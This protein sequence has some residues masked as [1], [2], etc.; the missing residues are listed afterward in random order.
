MAD[1]TWV[2]TD[3]GNEGDI[4]IAANWNPAAVP[5]AGED[6]YF[7]D[8]SQDVTAGLATLAAV[9][10][11]DVHFKK[12]YTGSI[13]DGAD[14]Y[15]QFQCSNLDIG[16][17]QGT[18]SPSGS[19]KLMIDAGATAATIIVHDTGTASDTGKS[20]VRLKCANA[21]T[22]IAVKKG[23]VGIAT[24]T[25]DTTTVGTINVNFVSNRQSDATVIIG[26]G[27][28]LT[29]LNKYG[30]VAYLNCAATTVLNTAGDLTT[31]GT[32]AIGTVLNVYG[33]TVYSN[34]SGTVTLTNISGGTVDTTRS[35]VA[36][37]FTDIAIENNGE[38]VRDPD[39]ITITN[40]IT[41]N[42]I[43]STK[44]K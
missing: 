30:S 20:A 39:V 18:G 1:R 12:T 10:L 28:T 35:T 5:G 14:G 2:G 31:D 4:N 15:L 43:L 27:V 22:T 44:G 34:S 26:S 23:T 38:F 42:V 19:G 21:A 33:G 41:S 36:R 32:G 37:T 17:H 24:E 3:A 25:G 13:N 6:V 11:D 16:Y 29:T 7:E 9:V 8:S 40:P